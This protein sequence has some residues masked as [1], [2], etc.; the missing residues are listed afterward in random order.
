MIIK[1]VPMSWLIAEQHR[2]DCGP[3][4]SGSIEARNRLKRLNT[5]PLVSLTRNGL[6]GMYHVGMDKGP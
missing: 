1:S 4:T 3:F 6:A 2:L 5:Q